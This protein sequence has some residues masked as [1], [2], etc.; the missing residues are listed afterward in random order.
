MENTHQRTGIPLRALSIRQPW[1]WM[2]MN[3]GK[4]IENRTWKT[5]FRGRF[6]VHASKGCTRDEYLFAAEF[7]KQA[8]DDIYRP[9]TLPPL[10][11]LDR[12]GIIG[13]IELTEC[14]QESESQWF[15][16]THGFVLKNPIPINF[17]PYKGRLGF[18]DISVPAD[19]EGK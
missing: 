12:G 7:A 11:S 16:G 14:V 10:K 13:S 9:V 3:I 8:I 15:V 5:N 18:F 4:D 19:I 6:L 2:I 1:A 17:I